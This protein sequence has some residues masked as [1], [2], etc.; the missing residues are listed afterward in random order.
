MRLPLRRVFDEKRRLMIPVLGGL[1]LNI[2]LYAG[3][4]LPDERECPDGGSPGE[5]G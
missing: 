5:L 4:R 3:D 1:A 2:V